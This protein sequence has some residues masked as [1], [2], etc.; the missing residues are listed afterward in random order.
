MKKIILGFIA[1]A[2]IFMGCAGNTPQQQAMSKMLVMQQEKSN[3]L[4]SGLVA[5]LGVGKAGSEQ[6][7]YNEADLNARADCTRMLETKVQQLVKSYEEQSGEQYTHHT[8]VV[9]KS[10]VSKTVQGITINK[11]DMEV[12]GGLYKVYAVAVMNPKIVEEAYLDAMK[13]QQADEN[14]VRASKG[15]AE[16][17]K[18]TADF[19]ASRR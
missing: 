18:A 19:E 8:E 4:S 3:Y 13:A 9:A 14:R 16:L 12:E 10:V 15:Y 6:L 1:S 17:E 5:G 2:A 11:M 7:A